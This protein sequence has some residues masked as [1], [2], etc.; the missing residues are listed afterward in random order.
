MARD[1]LKEQIKDVCQIEEVIGRYVP[2]LKPQGNQFKGLCPFHKEKTPS[3][4]VYPES[5]HFY[6]YGCQ[7]G[8]DVFTFIMDLENVEFP[9]AMR[10]VGQMVGIEVPDRPL[11]QASPVTG[12]NNQPTGIRKADLFALHERLTQWY[13]E[14][15]FSPAGAKA[16]EYC[17]RRRLSDELI[18]YFQLGY[19]P[20]SFDAVKRWGIEQRYSLELMLAAGVL[21]K[22]NDMDP[23]GRA[24][25]RWRQRLIFPIWNPQ[26]R[27]IGFSGRVLDP[28]QHGGKYVNS[29]ETPI[30]HKSRVLYG[31]PKARDAIREHGVCLLCEGQMDVIACHAAGIN[32]AVAPQ[33]TAFTEGQ[34]RLIKRYAEHI[35]LAFDADTA[36][37]A[38]AIKSIDAFV[39]A[40]LNARVVLMP[41]GQDPDSIVRD[42]GPDA[43]R[44]LIDSAADYFEF[45]LDHTIDQHDDTPAGKTSVVQTFLEAVAKLK[46]PI[47]RGEYCQLIA[48]RLGLRLE[49]VFQELNR[50]LAQQNRSRHFRDEPKDELPPPPA[51]NADLEDPV[52]KA[53]GDLLDLCLHHRDYAA[54]L[55]AE[56]DAEI[57]STTPTGRALNDLLAYTA[58]GEWD[59]AG[60][61]LLEDMLQYNSPR[62]NKA[63]NDPVY[64]KDVERRKL[65]TC[66]ADCLGRIMMN[67]YNQRI[68]ELEAELREIDDPDERRNRNRELMQ[69]YKERKQRGKGF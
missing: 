62:L 59:I 2:S 44:A 28:D 10:L 48:Q 9:E 12:D 61:L 56:L 23:D 65:Q 55:Q 13:Q 45:L 16:L 42:Q 53:E 21:T 1:D 38:A 66:Y 15:L 47:I 46:S 37:I 3:F 30:F 4:V 40:E 14:Q 63:L 27:V 26:G 22:K 68:A 8:G 25:D 50:M 33:G 34:A 58:Q 35:V 17:R 19:A 64:H 29:P 39:A 7:K 24:Y 60:D 49:P 18:R 5:Q 43:L 6:C 20:D 31:L 67:Y 57:I 69:L 54:Q 51:F 41:E 36:G 52:V 32:Y 11:F